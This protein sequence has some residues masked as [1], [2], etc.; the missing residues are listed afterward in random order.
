MVALGNGGA[1]GRRAG[2]S[3]LRH[4]GAVVTGGS[5]AARAQAVRAALAGA[6]PPGRDRLEAWLERAGNA[7]GCSTGAAAMLLAL[8]GAAVWWVL[9][10]D[11]RLALWPEAAGVVL[12]VL[13]AAVA[14]KLAGLAAADAWLWWISR[15]LPPA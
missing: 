4:R 8:A 7:C 15:R 5:R 3:L 11:A 10:R 6:D 9:A 12:V 1:P 2:P 13:G 14:G